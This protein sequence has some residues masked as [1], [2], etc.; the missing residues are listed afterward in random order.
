MHSSHGGNS[1]EAKWARAIKIWE[2]MIKICATE[3]RYK[4]IVEEE[5]KICQLYEKV[6]ENEELTDIWMEVIEGQ[7]GA[8]ET[9]GVISGIGQ[10]LRERREEEEVNRRDREKEENQEMV[11]TLMTMVEEMKRENERRSVKVMKCYTCGR[12][13][14]TKNNCRERRKNSDYKTGPETENNNNNKRNYYVSKFEETK[15]II[16]KSSEKE[17]ETGWTEVGKKEK[18]KKDKVRKTKV[19][20]IKK[21]KI[22][23]KE[24]NSVPKTHELGKVMSDKEEPMR[25]KIMQGKS[26]AD[27][28]MEQMIDKLNKEWK[29]KREEL[30]MD[31]SEDEREREEL[32]KMEGEMQFRAKEEEKEIGERSP[33]EQEKLR[34]IQEEYPEEIKTLEEIDKIEYTQATIATIETKEGEMT[35]GGAS[36]VAIPLQERAKELLNLYERTQVIRESDSKWRN[37]VFM[38]LEKTPDGKDKLRLLSD[39]TLLNEITKRQEYEIP[40]MKEMIEKMQGARYF[41]IIDLKDGYFQIQ[42]REEDRHK[43]AFRIMGKTYEYCSMPMGYKNAPMIFQEMMDRLL[44]K[45]IWKNKVAVYMDDIVVYTKTEEEHMGVVRQVMDILKENRLR[46]NIKKTRVCRREVKI[47]GQ[48]I[49]GM[50]RKP[51]EMK[52]NEALR[53]PKPVTAKDMRG[54]LGKMGYY[55]EFIQQ[56]A[57]LEIP[58]RQLITEAGDRNDKIVW[59]DLAEKAYEIMRQQLRD[60]RE[61]LL[62]DHKK[63][64]IVTTDASDYGISAVIEQIGPN[65]EEVPIAWKSRA[66]SQA[67]KNYGITEKEMLAVVWGTEKFQYYLKGRKFHVRTDHKA[68]TE[69]R[70]KRDFGK[71]KARISRWLERLGEFDFTIEYRPGIQLLTADLLSRIYER[72]LTGFIDKKNRTDSA[73][74]REETLIRKHTREEDGKLYWLLEHGERKEIP[75]EEDRRQMIWRAHDAT[76]HKGTR[77]TVEQIKEDGYYWRGIWDE[78]EKVIKECLT[79]IQNNRKTAAGHR[80][81]ETTRKLE[82]VA[83]DIMKEE[84]EDRYI[85]V[86]I[87]MYTRVGKIVLLNNKKTEEVIRGLERF[88]RERGRP[89]AIMCDNAKEFTSEEMEKYLVNKGTGQRKISIEAHNSN[90]RVER[91]I[92]TIRDDLAKLD[93]KRELK[94]RLREIELSYNN[95][96]HSG[97]RM[98]PEKAT[99][100][101]EAISERNRADGEYAKTFK[102]REREKFYEGEQVLTARKENMGNKQ[103]SEQ[104]RFLNRGVIIKNCGNDSYIVRGEDGKATKRSYKE[105]KGIPLAYK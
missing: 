22:Q 78:T 59:D 72:R 102:F 55:R 79:C 13:G 2:R 96:Y 88:I 31:D 42:T 71:G 25:R 36:N 81:I 60:A 103:K 15:E 44:K 91:F 97:I 53:F 68:L 92:R 9:A 61:L 101:Q 85:L 84:I 23:L 104:G 58:L 95:R 14:H 43:T 41:T 50:T 39:M 48:R 27:L 4:K 64:F 28:E 90:G 76:V 75:K 83:M 11:K 52:R 100:N 77:T 86:M 49:N 17:D 87:D 99:M 32:E 37:R 30:L 24:T 7:E 74:K 66:L 98:T 62:P 45:L 20:H 8:E 65:G 38:K 89:E 56:F 70:V 33:D 16:N 19:E 73:R 46:I 93:R 47:L 10:K 51:I 105:I 67:E 63:E 54:F 12:Y 3:W 80:F 18:V 35:E 34:Q 26:H 6:K 21:T 5:D 1:G 29:E 57:M 82:L 94:D 40:D 69:M